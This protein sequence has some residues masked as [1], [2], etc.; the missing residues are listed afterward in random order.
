MLAGF[1]RIQ[2]W[3]T[4]TF[5]AHEAQ[6]HQV[7]MNGMWRWPDPHHKS[8]LGPLIDE[9]FIPLDSKRGILSR[10][11]PLAPVNFLITSIY[12]RL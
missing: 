12:G 5:F 4:L 7:S 8:N 6:V 1:D 2:N 11:G 9:S 3:G 10:G